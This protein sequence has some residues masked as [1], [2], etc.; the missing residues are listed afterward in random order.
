M[1]AQ[2]SAARGGNPNGAHGNSRTITPDSTG[3]RPFA[4]MVDVATV[5]RFTRSWLG[6][7]LTMDREDARA[8]LSRLRPGDITDPPLAVAARALWHALEEGEQP[9]FRAVA[10][11]AERHGLTPPEDDANLAAFLVDLTLC[12]PPRRSVLDA[13]TAPAYMS[14]L[15]VGVNR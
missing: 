10:D 11:A 4:A 5:H 9:G 2:R 13:A 7:L 6:A 12:P 14:R 8:E 15:L 1:T 3:T